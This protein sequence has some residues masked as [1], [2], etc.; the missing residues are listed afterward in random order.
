[1]ML[2]AMEMSY[3]SS[4][5]TFATQTLEFWLSA[6]KHVSYTAGFLTVGGAGGHT[7]GP[8]GPFALP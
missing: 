4:E 1:M 2:S 3:L 7:D 5:V 6:S 8:H